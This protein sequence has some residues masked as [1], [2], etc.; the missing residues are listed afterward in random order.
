MATKVVA[1]SSLNTV[2]SYYSET[3][4][5]TLGHRLTELLAHEFRL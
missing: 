4:I 1:I 5:C 3:V 2:T